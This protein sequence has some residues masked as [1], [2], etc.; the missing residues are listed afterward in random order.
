MSFLAKREK[1][2]GKEEEGGVEG[3]RGVSVFTSGCVGKIMADGD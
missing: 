3:R 1:E 2:R